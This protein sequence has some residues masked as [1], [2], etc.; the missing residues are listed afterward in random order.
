MKYAVLFCLLLL[1]VKFVRSQSASDKIQV[2]EKTSTLIFRNGERMDM[3]SGFYSL[4]PDSQSMAFLKYRRFGKET[5]LKIY[6]AD[7]KEKKTFTVDALGQV[8]LA[9]DG[10]FVVYG[11]YPT[12]GTKDFKSFSFYN[13][14]G[15]KNTKEIHGLG[16]E[17]KC[18]FSPAGVFT[19]LSGAFITG[20][21]SLYMLD[22]TYNITG[23]AEFSNSD[24]LCYIG[25]LDFNDDSKEASIEMTL[26]TM[27]KSSRGKRTF[28]YKAYVYDSKGKLV[29]EKKLKKKE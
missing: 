6:D 3:A 25:S 15:V 5:E 28:D 24:K 23:Q 29:S 21:Y 18:E 27:P 11:A 1:N 2:Q 4:S 22:S 9:N 14:E 8:A 12:A 17:M 13:S 7:G 19:I 20:T 26:V 16:S 10:R